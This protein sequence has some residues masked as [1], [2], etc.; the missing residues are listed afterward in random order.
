MIDTTNKAIEFAKAQHLH[1]RTDDFSAA[2]GILSNS[3]LGLREELH[4]LQGKYRDASAAVAERDDAI[5]R[6]EEFVQMERAYRD[7]D[8]DACHIDLSAARAVIAEQERRIERLNQ[9]IAS[10][11]QCDKEDSLW[12]RNRVTEL[13]GMVEK[14]KAGIKSFE[15]Q[16]LTLANQNRD[17]FIQKVKELHAIK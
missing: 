12:L 5:A 6:A 7:K 9:Q 2:L 16:V 17:E 14:F 8:R 10:Q 13:E 4:V 1:G 15:T 11:E 3:V